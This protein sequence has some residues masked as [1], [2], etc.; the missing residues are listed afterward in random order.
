MRETGWMVIGAG[1]CGD[2]AVDAEDRRLRF[3]L[4]LLAER[5]IISRYLREM[6]WNY[7]SLL[8]LLELYIADHSGK[9]L[10]VS[11]LGYGSGTSIATAGRLTV[12][13]EARR[14]VERAR[15]PLD[16]RR[17][18]VALARRGLATMRCIFD[19]CAKWREKGR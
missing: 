8:M 7:A 16:A 2:I 18:H 11:S 12:E 6:S 3:C 9:L 10:S 5:Q 17:I 4:Q 19:D 1:H 13:L 14:L 15:D